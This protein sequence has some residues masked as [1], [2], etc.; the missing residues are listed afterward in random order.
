MAK[1]V[2]GQVPLPLE[3][4]QQL[5]RQEVEDVQVEDVKNPWWL[6]QM[7]QLRS[8]FKQ[9]ALVLG[10]PPN[11]TF[12]LFLFARNQPSLAMFAHLIPIHMEEST[13]W[14]YLWDKMENPAWEWN[15]H[16]M[17]DKYYEHTELPWED[18]MQIQV[19]PDLIHMPGQHLVSAFDLVDLPIFLA[20]QDHPDRDLAQEPAIR[21]RPAAS[22]EYE[23]AMAE[24]LAEFPLAAVGYLQENP[25]CLAGLMGMAL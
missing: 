20:G 17:L 1:V 12:W 11:Q 18:G 21:K 16:M 7:I 9:C 14:A 22:L 3:K 25:T 15:F 4:A 2:L 19:L 5:D 6:S 10:T 8:A 23:E 13:Y 24:A